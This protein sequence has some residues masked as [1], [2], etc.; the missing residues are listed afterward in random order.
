MVNGVELVGDKVL[1]K[2]LRKLSADLRDEIARDS[3]MDGGRIVESAAKQ[4]APKKSGQLRDSV[5]R[6]ARRSDGT[7]YVAVGPGPETNVRL[8][9]GRMLSYGLF[10]EFGVHGSTPKKPW[11]RPALDERRAAT[12]AEIKRSI[13][14]HI[15][16]RTK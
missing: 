2:K 3:L 7:W 5:T 11:L 1:L 16:R 8:A 13:W 15:Q 10:P 6:E 4:K 9:D 12:T 14:R